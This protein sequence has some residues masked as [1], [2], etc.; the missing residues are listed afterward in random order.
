ME[1]RSI[2]GRKALNTVRSIMD[3]VSVESGY[4]DDALKSRQRYS[5]VDLPLVNV[6]FGGKPKGQ[7]MRGLR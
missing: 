6:T 1:N 5:R 2:F 4:Q 3:R 7:R